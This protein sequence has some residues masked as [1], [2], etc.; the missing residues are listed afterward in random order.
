MDVMD[1]PEERPR[2]AAPPAPPRTVVV[3]RWLWIAGA[4]LSAGRSVVR[5]ADRR[6]LVDELTHA[7]PHLGQDE[8]DAAVSGTVLLGLL[9]CALVLGGYVLL[10]NRMARGANW[11]RVVLAG[12]GGASVLFGTISVV[13]VGAGVAGDL[14]VRFGAVDTLV[15]VAGVLLDVAALTLMFVPASGGYFQRR[16]ARVGRPPLR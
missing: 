4:L 9:L 12:L 6:A 15:G 8:V 16:S 13:A 2:V 5:L 1:R 11:A 7:V 14:G 3:S 10:A